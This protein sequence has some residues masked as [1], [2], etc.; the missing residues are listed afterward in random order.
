[1]DLTVGFRP[2]RVWA[3]LAKGEAAAEAVV[4]AVVQDLAA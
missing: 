3:S 2:S 4:Q 1:M